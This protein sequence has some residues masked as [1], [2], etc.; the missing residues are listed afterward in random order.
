MPRNQATNSLLFY[1]HQFIIKS[2]FIQYVTVN[3]SYFF[4][5]YVCTE[6]ISKAKKPNDEDNGDEKDA[7]NDLH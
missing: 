4:M 2:T 1:H 6:C 3:V 7:D 5:L